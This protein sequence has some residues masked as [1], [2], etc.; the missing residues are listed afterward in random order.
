VKYGMQYKV[1]KLPTYTVFKAIQLE[2]KWI[3]RSGAILRVFIN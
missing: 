2:L 1:F 3:L